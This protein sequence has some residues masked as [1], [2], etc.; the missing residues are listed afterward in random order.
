MFRQAE[1]FVIAEVTRRW[2]CSLLNQSGFR[3]LIEQ[4]FVDLYVD[5]CQL[6]FCGR[7]GK[8]EDTF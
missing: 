3:T 6:Q 7:Y 1:V 5:L 4:Y 2:R 8:E